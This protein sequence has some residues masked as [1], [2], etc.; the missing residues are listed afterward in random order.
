MEILSNYPPAVL[1]R[2][3]SPS[4][5][6]AAFVSYPNLAKFRDRLEEWHGEH[7]TDMQ[8][9]ERANRKR[10]P[11]PEPDP[12]MDARIAKGLRELAQHLKSGFSPGSV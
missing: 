9:F 6:L 8:R 10:L 7:V 12:E 1:E 5:G 4:R 2:A 11:E 3:V